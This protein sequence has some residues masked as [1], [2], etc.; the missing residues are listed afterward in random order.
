MNDVENLIAARAA[1]MA[2]HD[3][4]GV[5]VVHIF[6]AANQLTVEVGSSRDR[7]IGQPGL[8][9]DVLSD[10]ADAEAR[11]ASDIDPVTAAREAADAAT[12]AALAAAQR[13]DELTAEAD[14]L[15]AE[16]EAADKAEAERL[17]AEQ[18]AAD[19]A[20]AERIAAEKAATAEDER[21]AAEK[22]TRK[23]GK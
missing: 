5:Q 12:E 7:L 4:V 23:T 14:R 13:A 2:E 20:E 16:K 1:A 18:A 3:G 22:T 19:A 9:A 21:L 6:G 15:Q 17:A 10:L 8:L 11:D